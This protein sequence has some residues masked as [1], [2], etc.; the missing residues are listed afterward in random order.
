M[1]ATREYIPALDELLD[2]Q[3]GVLTTGAALAHMTPG[4]LEWRIKSGRWQQPCRGIV[5]SQSGPLT[6]SQR[7]WV[8]SLWAGP[9]SA[10]AGLTSARLFGLRGFSDDEEPAYVLRPLGRVLRAT[11][12]PLNVVVHYSQFLTE[13]DIHPARRPPRTRAARSLVDAASWRRTDR[14]AQAILA[15][16]VQQGL[17]LPAHLAADL[18]RRTRVRRRAVMLT[19]VADIAGG[20]RALSELDLLNYVVRPFRLP[21]PDRQARR[22]DPQGRARWLDAVWER[23]RLIVEIDGAGHLDILQYQD[24]MSRDNSFTLQGYNTL[25]YAAYSVR[26]QADHVASQIAQALRNVGMEW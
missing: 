2:D 26:Y 22:T 3:D 5:V 11:R 8:A 16:G 18:D 12:P 10:L 17:V 14:G 19:T 24:D 20:S 6:A 7:L 25:R 23:A 9:G 13:D 15:A 4:A 1:T 21:A